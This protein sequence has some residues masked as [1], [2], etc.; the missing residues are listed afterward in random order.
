MSLSVSIVTCPASSPSAALRKS[1]PGFAGGLGHPCPPG[2]ESSG[3]REPSPL[4]GLNHSPQGFVLLAR[5]FERRAADGWRT[6]CEFKRGCTKRDSIYLW[7]LLRQ[8]ARPPYPMWVRF[9]IRPCA[10]EGYLP[11]RPTPAIQ[12]ITRYR[13]P[14]RRLGS[15]L[16]PLRASAGSLDPAI[17]TI[18]E[19]AGG[20]MPKVS[21]SEAIQYPMHRPHQPR[22]RPQ[23][24]VDNHERGQ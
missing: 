2:A 12:L 19:P 24:R 9:V 14:S 15:D 17:E 5:R 20:S 13:L 18:C 22:R 4:R 3:F 10:S 8:S 1:A 7:L 16:E 6:R 23:E 21:G 11:R